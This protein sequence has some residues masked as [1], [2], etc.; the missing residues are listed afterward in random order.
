MSTKE[1]YVEGMP[2]EVAKRLTTLYG[3]SGLYHK[4]H[5]INDGITELFSIHNLPHIEKSRR[6]IIV[7]LG[8][9]TGKSQGIVGLVYST[10]ENPN[11]SVVI[12][13]TTHEESSKINMKNAKALG[14]KVYK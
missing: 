10:K 3:N 5:D 13:Q 2:E 8:A 6:K 1:F 11:E 12:S 4:Y 14:L 7:Q 9:I